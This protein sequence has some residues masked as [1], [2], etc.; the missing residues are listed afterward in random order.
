MIQAVQGLPGEGMTLRT[1][2]FKGTALSASDRQ[3][4][5]L[6][7]R[8]RA[9]LINPT[10]QAQVDETLAKL[11]QRKEQG[12]KPERVWSLDYTEKCTPWL[13]DVFGFNSTEDHP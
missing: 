1:V 12:A 9:T 3:T 11:D 7:E 13:G 2:S 8:V 10:L 5:A 6:R 4:M